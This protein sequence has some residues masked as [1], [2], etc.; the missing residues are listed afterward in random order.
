MQFDSSDKTIKIHSERARSIQEW[1]IPRSKPELGS[2]MAIVNYFESHA[3]YLKRLMIPLFAQLKKDTFEWVQAEVIS[4]NKVKFLVALCISNAIYCPDLPISVMSDVSQ[5]YQASLIYQWIPDTLELVLL[6]TK[7]I[8]LST[9]IQRQESIFRELFGCNAALNVAE[10]YLL[11]STAKMNYLCTDAIGL[12]YL[13]RMKSFSSF[14][15]ESAIYLSTWQNLSILHF[16]GRSLTLVDLLS[17]QIS[18]MK[19]ETGSNI[20]KSQAECIPSLQHIK[21]G[22]LIIHFDL[23]K[24]LHSSSL[25]ELFDC[26]PCMYEYAYKN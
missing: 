17:R 10:T 7:S 2:I 20:S 22:S 4:W 9:A 13:H 6:N 16:P 1:R 3:P 8:L 12:S 19:F 14:L 25:S 5:I 11:Q 15:F 18:N 23:L 24:I 21:P 26:E